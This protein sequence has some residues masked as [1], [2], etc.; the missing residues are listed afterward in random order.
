[1]PPA[2]MPPAAVQPA[3]APRQMVPPPAGR[4]APP[5]R[6]G[7]VLVQPVAAPSA[8]PPP[9]LRPGDYDPAN[10][11]TRYR[12]HNGVWWFWLPSQ[13][14]AFWNGQQWIT[15]RPREY[16]QWRLQQ[17][18]HRYNDSDAR[19][20]MSR[21]R[22]VD[23]WRERMG[24][25]AMGGADRLRS[26]AAADADYHRQV[27]RFHDTLMTT[28]YDYRLGTPGHGLFDADPDRVISQS[29]R[30]NYATSAGGYM[31]GAL[32]GPFGY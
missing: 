20:S 3:A 27:D 28:P 17:L 26:T 22:D 4:A 21:Y 5:Q 8:G 30:L 23:R 12:L 32:R 1:M 6:S 15:T 2:A 9:S 16:Q 29:G 14:W 11:S 13:Q 25:Q 31:G 10:M 18:G 24:R 7:S 19:D